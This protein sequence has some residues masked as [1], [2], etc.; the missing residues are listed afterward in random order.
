MCQVNSDAMFKITSDTP[1]IQAK[2][3]TRTHPFVQRE[4][5]VE[6]DQILRLA[7][8]L[9]KFLIGENDDFDKSKRQLKANISP[10]LIILDTAHLIDSASWELFALIRD[11]CRCIGIILL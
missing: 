11:E 5:F 9:V 6:K 4:D 7:L 1:S 10:I 3:A 2:P 8:N